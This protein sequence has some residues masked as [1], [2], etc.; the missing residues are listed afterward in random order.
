MDTRCDDIEAATTTGHVQVGWKDKGVKTEAW[1]EGQERKEGGGRL[2]ASPVSTHAAC[3][4]ARWKVACMLGGV[5]KELE[6]ARGR[7]TVS[8]RGS[9][10]STGAFCLNCKDEG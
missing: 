3:M 1:F 5:G 6:S 8:G 7:A 10:S 2:L 9:A 4:C